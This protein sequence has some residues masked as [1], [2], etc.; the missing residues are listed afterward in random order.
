MFPGEANDAARFAL[1]FGTPVYLHLQRADKLAQAISRVRALQTGLWHKSSDGSE[2]E[3]VAPPQPTA[4][5]GAMIAKIVAELEDN[6]ARW[7]DWFTAQGI[8]P[9]QLTYE[10]LAAD[11]RG[12][13]ARVLDALGLDPALAERAEVR[14]SRLADAESAE[15][16]A[17]SRTEQR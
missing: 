10:E 8:E 15:W 14:T 5:D 17:R 7:N 12:T 4:Y 13:L 16:M 2:R 11:P 3:R 6:E 1:A 9:L